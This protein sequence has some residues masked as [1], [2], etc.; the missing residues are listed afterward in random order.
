MNFGLCGKPFISFSHVGL[1]E[2]PLS[3]GVT[4]GPHELTGPLGQDTRH[5]SGSTAEDIKS[6]QSQCQESKIERAGRH[7]N[8]S[9]WEKNLQLGTF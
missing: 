5:T 3:N 2:N 1:I 7:I 4:G 6:N 8:E 9:A